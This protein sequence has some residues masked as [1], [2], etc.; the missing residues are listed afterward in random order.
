MVPI[1]IL[2]LLPLF[3]ITVFKKGLWWSTITLAKILEGGIVEKKDGDFDRIDDFIAAIDNDDY[4]YLSNEID[5][6]NFIDYMIF[7]SYIGNR[8][9]PKNNVRF[10]C[11]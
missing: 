10:F 2:S 7:E 9:W 11:N 1:L 3:I 4:S 8:D 6:D 5:V